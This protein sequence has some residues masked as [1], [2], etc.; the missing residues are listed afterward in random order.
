M[1]CGSINGFPLDYVR[2]AVDAP[3][4]EMYLVTVDR[5]VQSDIAAAAAA[6]HE[7]GRDYDDAVAE[8]LVERIGSEIDKRVDAKLAETGKGRRRLA[9]A[10]LTDRH[11]GLWLGVGIGSAATGIAGLIVSAAIA[12]HI[13]DTGPPNVPYDVAGDML[14]GFL[15][16]WGLLV[17][18]FIVYTW[19][20]HVRGRE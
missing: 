9:D 13:Q 19:A 10:A 20:R 3:G 15:C 1:L 4:I 12:P 14:A 18:A 7:L 6:H 11:P 8:S 17:V 5:R 16:A 2:Q